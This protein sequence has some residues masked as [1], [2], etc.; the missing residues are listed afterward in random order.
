[1]YRKVRPT[2]P[3]MPDVRPFDYPF[4]CGRYWVPGALIPLT[5]VTHQKYRLVVKWQVGWSK[6]LGTPPR[7]SLWDGGIYPPDAIELLRNGWTVEHTTKPHKM[8]LK[9]PKGQKQPIPCAKV[10]G[11]H[12]TEDELFTFNNLLKANTE[13][14]EE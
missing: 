3:A 4:V 14:T 13:D 6:L 8:Y 7:V 2:I 5:T 11:Y 12:F 10:Y 1:M 9:P